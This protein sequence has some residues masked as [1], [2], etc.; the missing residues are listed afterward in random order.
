MDLHAPPSLFAW[1]TGRRRATRPPEPADMGTAF[2]MEQWLD[3]AE[4]LM[5]AEAQ[6]RRSWLLRW[7]PGGAAR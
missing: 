3:D 7:L 2:G 4:Q 6:P 1:L 5:A